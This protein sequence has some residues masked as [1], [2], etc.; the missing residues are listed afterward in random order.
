MKNHLISAANYYSRFARFFDIIS[1][2]NDY[3]VLEKINE[4]P[5]SFYNLVFSLEK[6]PCIIQRSLKNLLKHNLGTK[7]DKN[8]ES[9]GV[10]R[11]VIEIT[12]R[13]IK[14]MNIQKTAEDIIMVACLSGI[15]LIL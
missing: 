11:L 6:N 10:G 3:K 15:P 12:K 9:T 5:S 8:Y 4:S 14:T 2:P 7:H 1:R 13:D